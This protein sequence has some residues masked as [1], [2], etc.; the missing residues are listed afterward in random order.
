MIDINL[1]CRSN[2]RILVLLFINYYEQLYSIFYI[3]YIY[4]Y[5]FILSLKYKN[6]HLHVLLHL[7]K[8]LINYCLRLKYVSNITI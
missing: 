2:K 3:L 8:L 7:D 5:I 4:S 1:L 6:Q